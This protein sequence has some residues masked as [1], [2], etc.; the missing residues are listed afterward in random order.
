MLRNQSPCYH[1]VTAFLSCLTCLDF[2]HVHG[3]LQQPWMKAEG[4]CGHVA[5]PTLHLLYFYLEDTKKIPVVKKTPL[6]T[7][8][9]KCLLPMHSFRGKNKE[10]KEIKAFISFQKSNPHHIYCKRESVRGVTERG[11]SHHFPAVVELCLA[12]TSVAFTQK[13]AVNT[14][15]QH[16]LC[17]SN[18]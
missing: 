3:A 2:I 18:P 10:T 9:I 14:A 13:M 17:D 8:H 5:F 7:E 11:K 16:L 12:K 6:V 15:Q 4:S 1:C